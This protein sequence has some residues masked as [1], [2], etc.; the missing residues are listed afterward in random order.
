MLGKLGALTNTPADV[1][2]R[3]DLAQTHAHGLTDHDASLTRL[4]TSQGNALVVQPSWTQQMLDDTSPRS[5]P[6]L[7]ASS[8]GRTRARRERESRML[9][10]PP[11]DELFETSALGE[12][13]LILLIMGDD[14]ETAVTAGNAEL[15]RAEKERVRAWFNEERFPYDLGFMRPRRTVQGDE[16]G[17]LRDAVEKWQRTYE[18][19]SSYQQGGYGGSP[20]PPRYNSPQYNPPRQGQYGYE[21]EYEYESPQEAYRQ[22]QQGQYNQQG[23]SK[24]YYSQPSQPPSQDVGWYWD[25]E[26]WVQ[27][28]SGGY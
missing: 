18:R 27:Q 23:S 4:D 15:R 19:G 22:R 5:Y 24:Q 13:S 21:D 28:Q 9:G 2:L 16:L 12:V 8:L 17:F 20:A 14:V 7:N 3:L 1:N 10:N 26:T 25:G 11:L 6:W